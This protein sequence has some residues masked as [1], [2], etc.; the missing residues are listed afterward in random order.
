MPALVNP[1]VT[2]QEPDPREQR[3]FDDLRKAITDLTTVTAVQN[4]RIERQNAEIEKAHLLIRS[5]QTVEAQL[6]GDQ[7]E[8]YSRITALEQMLSEERIARTQQAEELGTVKAQLAMADGRL[9][10]QRQ[11]LTTQGQQIAILEDDKARLIGVNQVWQ[12]RAQSYAA[13]LKA[14]GEVVDE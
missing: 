12:L 14:L 10:K 1:T 13:R 9:Q 5:L 7:R 11:D 6:R 2:I 3:N 4:E 8:A